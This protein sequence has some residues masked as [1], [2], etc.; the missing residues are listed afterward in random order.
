LFWSRPFRLR[1]P[2]SIRRLILN[3][4]VADASKQAS[5][6]Q[7]IVF[8]GLP[9][10]QQ[11]SAVLTRQVNLRSSWKF[12]RTKAR[13]G[14]ARCANAGLRLIQA[15]W[16]GYSGACGHR[17]RRCR[18]QDAGGEV[19]S[20]C[21]TGRNSMMQT[22]ASSSRRLSNW[23]LCRQPGCGMSFAVKNI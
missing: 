22:K 4:A 6:G 2:F 10:A 21:P 7:T 8:C 17:D 18:G 13:L 14:D 11:P 12:L 23:H 1:P 3:P 9:A 16:A 5:V 20:P 15:G 19:A